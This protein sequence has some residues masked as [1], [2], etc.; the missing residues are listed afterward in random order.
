MT[1]TNVLFLYRYSVFFNYCFGFWNVPLLAR[2]GYTLLISSPKHATLTPFP[3]LQSGGCH[4][5]IGP[6][7]LA[8]RFHPN[9]FPPGCCVDWRVMELL[10]INWY[11]LE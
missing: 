3:G 9:R 1:S 10:G 8:Q 5:E 7:A 2:S 11:G 4:G 6:Q